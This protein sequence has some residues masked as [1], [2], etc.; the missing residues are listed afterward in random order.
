MSCAR[1][2]RW[3]HWPAQKAFLPEASLS[4]D[5]PMSTPAVHASSRYYEDGMTVGDGDARRG[6]EHAVPGHPHRPS[7]NPLPHLH[8]TAPIPP[9]APAHVGC[10]EFDVVVSSNHRRRIAN[11]GNVPPVADGIKADALLEH[12]GRGQVD[13]PP[14]RQRRD[15]IP[16]SHRDVD[17]LLLPA[18]DRRDPVIGDYLRISPIGAAGLSR[19]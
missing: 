16:G 8:I 11:R 1:S 19:R 12:D 13:C 10:T 9:C 6:T 2:P 14:Y 4:A 3:P 17:P 7:A 18:P 5:G 15:R